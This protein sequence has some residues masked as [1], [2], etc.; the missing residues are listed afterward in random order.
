[1]TPR[2]MFEIIENLINKYGFEEVEIT[3][4]SILDFFREERRN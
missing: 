1:M 2:D 4:E 3:M